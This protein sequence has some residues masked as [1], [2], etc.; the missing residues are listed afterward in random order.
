MNDRPNDVDAEQAVLGSLIIDP[1]AIVSVA[2]TLKADDFFT[3]HHAWIYEALIALGACADLMTIAR[4]MADRHMLDE[5]GGEAY[6]AQLTGM[7]PT[8]LNVEAYAEIVKRRAV[9]RRLLDALSPIAIDCLN[10]ALETNELVNRT[11][12]TIIEALS[13]VTV[14]QSVSL[15]E[16]I[17]NFYA[18]FDET[19]RTGIVPGIP[20]GIH[21]FDSMVGGWKP[22]RLTVVGALP[23]HGKTTLMLN[24]LLFASKAGHRCA[25]FSLEMPEQDLVESLVSN[26]AGVDVSPVALS[27]L[28]KTD[29]EDQRARIAYSLQ[30]IR[31]LPI[32]LIY[33]P[34]VSPA[35]MVYE[36]RRL[37]ARFGHI[38]L[39]AFDYVQLGRPSV[40]SKQANRE[41]DVSAVALGLK[42][43]AGE[44]SAHVITGSQVNEQGDTRESKAITQH[45][46]TVI[47][48]RRNDG[49][50]PCNMMALTAE[51]WKNRK[52]KTGEIPLM[53]NKPFQ[54]MTAM[55]VRKIQL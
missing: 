47:Y 1:S 52:G 50:A 12:S 30:R 39:V 28:N 6:L 20:T 31:S 14:K 19:L 36:C 18:D 41:Q 5:S 49:I 27:R 43:A 48:L 34:S 17:D 9:S 38:E 13:G 55:E 24:T 4:W 25:F 54:R 16:A 29:Q 45:A 33:A 11:Q 22:T 23:G 2:T 37:G 44:L 32:H 21:E 8:A 53:F 42:Q 35:D 10:P 26:D 51:F 3:V 40:Q 15:D 7:V 46:D